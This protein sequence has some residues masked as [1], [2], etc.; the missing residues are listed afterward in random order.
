MYPAVLPLF[1]F[2][3]IVETVLNF[4]PEISFRTLFRPIAFMVYN[5]L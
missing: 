1:H 5:I 4:F 3:T 2:N